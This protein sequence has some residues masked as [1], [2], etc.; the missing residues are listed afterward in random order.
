[1][2]LILL[3]IF[4][5]ISISPNGWT[6]Q[7]LGYAWLQNDFE[8]ATREKAAGQY[9]LLILDGHNSHCTFK[10]CNY[11]ADHKII[12]ICLPA[13]TTHALQPCDVGA[14]GPLAQSWKRVVILAS[15]SLISI[16]KDNLLSYYH[17]ARSEAL[18]PM[19]IQSAFRKTGIWPLNRHSI[20]LSAFEPS[21]NTTT[22]AAQPLPAH[23]P[24]ILVPTPNPTPSPS[25]AVQVEDPLH[26]EPEEP[27]ER[28]HIEVPPPLPGTSS[29]QA[30]RGENMMLRDIIRQAGIALEEDYAQM[31]LMDFENERLRKQ[32]FA[33]ENRSKQSKRT[34]ARARHMTGDEMLDFLAR[35]DWEGRMK[36]IFKEAAPQFKILKKNITSYQKAVEKAKSVEERN[37]K[38]AATAVA[39][40]ERTRGRVRGTR[41]GRRGRG[42]GARGRGAAGHASRDTDRDDSNSSGTDS[43][44]SRGS[45]DS[46]SESDTD[47]PIPRSRRQRPL[48]V[49]RGHDRNLSIEEA[50][51]EEV[52]D[53][54]E[55]ELTEYPQPRPQPRP[56]PRI[57][58][59]RSDTQQ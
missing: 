57:R 30:L 9:R 20:P 29:R 54:G 12:V 37:K 15:Q 53:E 25:A 24:S 5:S 46:E 3:H 4:N 8:P 10:F 2:H 55:N 52:M 27:M 16:R 48:R 35:Q 14:F 40:A 39:R 21:K 43:S 49:I 1:M 18:K 44:E 45:S 33:K 19:T 32:I 6:D 28:Y 56:R 42:R 13:H 23:L 50:N 34:S 41:G 11:S 17:T 7:E 22:E 47:I 26:D 31:K 36:D 38:K 59:R 51:Q 58:R